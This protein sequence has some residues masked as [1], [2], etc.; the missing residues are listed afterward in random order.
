MTTTAACSELG[1][2]ALAKKFLTV[3]D[4]LLPYTP[5]CSHETRSSVA[6]MLLQANS[7]LTQ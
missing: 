7:R 3:A 6:E 1:D 2:Y 5:G 4:A